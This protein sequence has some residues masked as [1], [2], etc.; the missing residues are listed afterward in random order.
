MV[1]GKQYS[2]PAERSKRAPRT[3]FSCL[4]PLFIRGAVAA[5]CRYSRLDFTCA[6]V[7][8][9]GACAEGRNSVLRIWHFATDRRG[10]VS[11][12]F[13]RCLLWYSLSLSLSL[14]LSVCLY[15]VCV[16]ARVLSV[17]ILQKACFE[18]GHKL[19]NMTSSSSCHKQRG[20]L[21]QNVC[22]ITPAKGE[23]VAW[24]STRSSPAT[25][26]HEQQID[27]S[28]PPPLR[29]D[30]ANAWKHALFCPGTT[31]WKARRSRRGG[32]GRDRQSSCAPSSPGK[33]AR[34]A[35]GAGLI[36]Q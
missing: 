10:R 6:V 36:V 35:P 32:S 33:P 34:P 29:T 15:C 21:L 20:Y 14:S 30:N 26:S 18:G 22:L 24:I 16:C 23:E 4:Q 5:G 8:R 19:P 28:P 1:G 2:S 9:C 13:R 11:F 12:R 7:R 31:Y 17:H 3:V 27:P 25:A